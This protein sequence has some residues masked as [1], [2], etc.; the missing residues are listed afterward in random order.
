MKSSTPPV[1]VT[2]M[3]L[4]FILSIGLEMISWIDDGTSTGAVRQGCVIWLGNTPPT[5]TPPGTCSL[6]KQRP[7]WVES[8]P[9]G[10]TQPRLTAAPGWWNWQTQGI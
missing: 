10:A 5:R 4:P 3:T 6:G 1:I 8:P 2:A 7:P 9:S